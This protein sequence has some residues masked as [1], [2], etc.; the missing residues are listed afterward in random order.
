M[1]VDF[2]ATNHIQSG[3]FRVIFKINADVHI[4][5]ADPQTNL[6]CKIN[7]DSM[8]G[9]PIASEQGSHLSYLVEFE[10]VHWLEESGECTNYGEG[11]EFKSL[12]HCVAN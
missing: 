2:N 8:T 1:K 7:T 6:F 10:E 9:D 5:L 12:A 11:A 4:V 3:L